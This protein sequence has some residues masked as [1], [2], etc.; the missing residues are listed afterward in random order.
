M[1]QPPSVAGWSGSRRCL[2]P[3]VHGSEEVLSLFPAQTRILAGSCGSL[4]DS[5]GPG[6]SLPGWQCCSMI[7][8][9]NVLN[10]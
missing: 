8:M 7:D 3:A 4:G 1:I 6:A 9:G 5:L 2:A 10:V